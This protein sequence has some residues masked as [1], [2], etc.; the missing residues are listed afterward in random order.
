MKKYPRSHE[1]I[2]WSLFGAG[3]MVVAFVL[4]TLILT[5]GIIVPLG[6]APE[7]AL[8][9]QQTLMFAQNWWGALFIFTVIALPL[10]HAAHR[11]YHS[12]HDLHIHGP[13]NLMLTLFYGGASLLS[14]MTLYGLIAVR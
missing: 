1:P 7:S 4:P 3:G 8:S 11:I 6:F 5:T 10:F 12:L 9:Y 2:V 13:K 14:L